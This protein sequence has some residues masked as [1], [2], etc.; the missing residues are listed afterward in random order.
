MKPSS[1]HSL[2]TK[3]GF[4]GPEDY[5]VLLGIVLILCFILFYFLTTWHALS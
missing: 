1:C 3:M 5:I 4:V 2:K